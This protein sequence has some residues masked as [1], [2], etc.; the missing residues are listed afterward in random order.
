MMEVSAGI[1]IWK[2][3]R[4]YIKFFVCT[5]GGPAWSMYK[6]YKKMKHDVSFKAYEEFLKNFVD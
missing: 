1:I 6:S 4:D 5:P 2:K 3:D